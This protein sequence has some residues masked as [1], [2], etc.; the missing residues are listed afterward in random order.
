MDYMRR[1]RKVHENFI[2][3]YLKALL[4]DL[5]MMRKDVQ[6]HG[7]ISWINVCN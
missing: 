2:H 3:I 7:I 6:R 1:T 4:M 5:D